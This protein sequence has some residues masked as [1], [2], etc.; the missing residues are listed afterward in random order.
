MYLFL[1]QVPSKTTHSLGLTKTIH[2]YAPQKIEAL[3]LDSGHNLLSYQA[4]KVH[5]LSFKFIWGVSGKHNNIKEI[6]SVG[7]Q[8]LEFISKPTSFF[9]ATETKRRSEYTYFFIRKFYLLYLCE[10]GKNVIGSV[11]GDRTSRRTM[12]NRKT[13]HLLRILNVW[14]LHSASMLGLNYQSSDNIDNI[15]NTERKLARPT[16]HRLTAI[17]EKE[18]V[19]WFSVSIVIWDQRL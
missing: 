16:K 6:I 5:D 15:S 18:K 1:L 14:H 8:E 19:F 3:V 10:N 13:E 4:C 12:F 2:R 9:A 17:L 11:R 7:H